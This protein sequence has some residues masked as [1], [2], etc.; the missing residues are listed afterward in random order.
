MKTENLRFGIVLLLMTIVLASCNTRKNMS[1]LRDLENQ[2][3][4]QGTPP[5]PKQIKINPDDNLYISVKTINPEINELFSS[6]SSGDIGSSPRWETPAGQHING[7]QVNPEGKIVLPIIGTVQ[8]AGLSLTEAQSAIQQQA[9]EYLKD[10]NIQVKLLNYKV[11]VL[12]EV[13]APGV[14][15]NYNNSLTIL[16]AIGMANGITEYAGLTNVSVIR[17][18]EAGTKSYKVDLTKKNV[19]NSDAYY[20]YPN[21]V[22]YIE[23]QSLKN[24]RLNSGMYALFLSSVSTLVVI[25]KYLSD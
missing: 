25:L 10:A 2:A 1:Y 18:T 23:P 20:I 21:D 8:V 13:K 19:L 9:N 22:I 14:Y 24:T 5:P 17:K 12:G 6:N 3:V 15:Y 7:Y 11:N 4:L 16:E